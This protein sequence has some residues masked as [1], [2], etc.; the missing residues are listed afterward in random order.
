MSQDNTTKRERS[1]HRGPHP[2]IVAAVF[3]ALFIAGLLP[4]T[5]IASDTHFPAPG[6]PPEEIVAYFRDHAGNV[7]LCAF[8]QFCSAIPLGVFTATMVSRLRYLGVTAAGPAIGFVGG[9]WA[10]L[11][12]ASSALVHMGPRS[13]VSRPMLE[14]PARFTS[15]PSPQVAPATACRS[16]SSSPESPYPQASPSCSPVGSFSRASRSQPSGSFPRSTSSFRSSCS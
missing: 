12:T 13:R 9:L 8:F 15:S 4:V 16:A 1:R 11:A 14:S 10:T 6:Q 5:L 2:G 7:R 3:A